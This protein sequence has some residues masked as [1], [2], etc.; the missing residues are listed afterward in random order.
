MLWLHL[1]NKPVVSV[2]IHKTHWFPAEL[3]KLSL[4][5]FSKFNLSLRESVKQHLSANLV[6]EACEWHL[7]RTMKCAGSASCRTVLRCDSSIHH[8]KELLCALTF[9]TP[10]RER[11]SCCCCCWLWF[12]HSCFFI[13]IQQRS[14][15]VIV[16]CWMLVAG[17]ERDCWAHWAMYSTLYDYDRLSAV[18]A[19]LWM[20]RASF[21]LG[22]C[23]GILAVTDTETL[24]YFSL[25]H[26]KLDGSTNHSVLIVTSC[27]PHLTT[28]LLLLFFLDI[29][30]C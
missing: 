16:L 12:I 14:G 17:M 7:Q 28:V 9:C 23:S 30:L 1:Q 13:G 24:K 2:C 4:L 19:H 22:A 18:S 6:Y 26:T 3:G 29:C 20:L 27:S 25:N 21:I 8:C 5:T 10:W 11:S 15:G